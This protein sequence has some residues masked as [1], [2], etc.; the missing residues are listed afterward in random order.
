MNTINKDIINKIMNDK[1]LL[2]KI[3]ILLWGQNKLL[4]IM[5]NPRI[6]QVEIRDK[7]FLRK[8]LIDDIPDSNHMDLIITTIH[9]NLDI[10]IYVL[11]RQLFCIPSKL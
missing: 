6:R 11:S 10:K 3:N 7:W 9:S 4:T 2:Y 8:K 5:L 1:K